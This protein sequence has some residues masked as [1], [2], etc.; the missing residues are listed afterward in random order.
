MPKVQNSKSHWM[1]RDGWT[2]LCGTEATRWKRDSAV[3][4]ART[5][6]SPPA[7]THFST[8]NVQKQGLNE[9]QCEQKGKE[10]TSASSNVWQVSHFPLLLQTRPQTNLERKGFTSVHKAGTEAQATEGCCLVACSPWLVQVDFWYSAELPD[11]GW[12]CPQCPHQS[13][14]KEMP[15]RLAYRPIWWS[16]FLSWDFPVPDDPSLCQDDKKQ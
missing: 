6:P 15:H 13:L 7:K 9:G 1:N 3:S 5:Y 10:D 4:H 2:R 16:H 12:N 11:E 14:I 8:V